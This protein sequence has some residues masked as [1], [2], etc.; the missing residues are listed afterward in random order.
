MIKIQLYIEQTSGAGDFVRLDLLDDEAI[1]LTSSI[2]DV[3]DI[4][5]ILADFTRSFKIPANDTNNKFF[6]HFYNPDI[7]G[8]DANL[9][10][11]A[12]IFLNHQLHREGF[13]YLDNVELKNQKAA[14]YNITFYGGIII[15]KDKIRDYK[16]SSLDLSSYNHNFNATEIKTGF[17]T[18]LHSGNVI[19]PLITPKK[20]LYYDSSSTS[21]R[22]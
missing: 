4:S 20:R 19:Y 21:P 7:D 1:S 10:R 22:S 17:Q 13:I 14:S 15:L 3:K 8:Y 12:K 9:K 5:K 11:N 16:L 18:G 6:K 2:Q